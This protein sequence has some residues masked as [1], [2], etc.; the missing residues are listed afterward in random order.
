MV[1]PKLICDYDYNVLHFSVETLKTSN[2]TVVDPQANLTERLGVK[3]LRFK[4]CRSDSISRFVKNSYDSAMRTPRKV[5]D[6]KPK[7]T[8]TRLS[9]WDGTPPTTSAKT[10]W[11]KSR[12][13]S[14]STPWTRIRKLLFCCRLFGSINIHQTAKGGRSNSWWKNSVNSLHKTDAKSL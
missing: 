14:G 8:T 4:S 9:R 12:Y 1:S 10:D 5:T 11:Q 3:S 2:Q 7:P 6:G 13:A